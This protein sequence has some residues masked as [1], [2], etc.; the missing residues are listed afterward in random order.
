[1]SEEDKT[2]DVDESQSYVTMSSSTKLD[3]NYANISIDLS[4]SYGA[5]GSIYVADPYTYHNRIAGGITLDKEG[6]ITLDKDSDIKLGEL[7]LKDFIEKVNDRLGILVTN[8]KL[9]TE[10]E[11]LRDLA[12]QYKKLEAELTAQM[13]VWDILKSDHKSK[14]S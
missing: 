11:Q 1:M 7:S 9:E 10:F 4:G 2:Q 3:Y 8:P 6:G 5:Q 12:N 14:K 13:E